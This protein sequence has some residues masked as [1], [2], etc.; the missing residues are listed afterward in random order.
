MFIWVLLGLI[1]VYNLEAEQV[2][3]NT[4]FLNAQI[5]DGDKIYVEQ[6]YGFWEPGKED[7]V[8]L[9]LRALYGLQQS[10]K[11]WYQTSTNFLSK[12]DYEPL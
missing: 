9:L 2:D 10:L 12:L 4:A 6:P 5:N 3:M 8:C 11:L 1:A 7:W